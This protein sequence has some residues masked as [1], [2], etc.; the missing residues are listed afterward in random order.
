MCSKDVD[1]NSNNGSATLSRFSILVGFLCALSY[2]GAFVGTGWVYTKESYRL[3][4]LNLYTSVTFKI[5]LWRACHSFKKINAS[6]SK[7]I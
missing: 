7:Y 6:I 5:G 3:T 4:N 2:F 1:G